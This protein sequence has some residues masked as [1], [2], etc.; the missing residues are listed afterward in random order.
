MQP[1]AGELL[2]RYVGDW[3][4]FSLTGA[5]ADCQVFLRTNIG[6]A[7][8]L[9]R[10]II[11]EICEPEVQVETA[12]RDVPMVFADG[13]WAVEFALAE[14]GWF[15]AKAYVVDTNGK[16]HWP[17]GEN[18]GLSVHP[19]DARCANTIYC[20]FPRMFGPNKF[21]RSTIERDDD[22][23]IRRLDEEGY[24]V[25]PPSGTF[26]DV[27]AELP[28][29][30]GTLG[31][32]I[33]H[34]LPVNSTPTTYAR[35]GR[36]G[37]PYACG[38]LTDIDSALVE[39]DKR[40]TGVQQFCELTDAV[41]A[42]GG[43][44]FL[45]LVI[46]HTGWGSTLQENH[47]EW[48]LRDENGDFA[49]PGAWGVTWGDL[50]EL[51]PHHR[52]LW[53]HLADAFLTWCRRGVDG[54]RCDAG[55]KVP[56]PV[57]R[58]IIARVRD[59]FPDTIFLLEGLG[60][61]WEDTEALLTRGGMQWAYSELF[62]EFSGDNLA[63]YLD[64]A[65]LQSL[66][67]G[68]LIHYSETHDNARLADRGRTW[69]LMRNQLSALTSVNG[70]Y[71]F[72]NGVE[73]L[74]DE[75][76]NVH[77]ARGMNWGAETNIIPELSRL[78]QLLADHPSFRDGAEFR[79]LSELGS[80]VFALERSSVCGSTV[81]ILVNSDANSKCEIELQREDLSV[82]DGCVDLLTG[83]ATDAE[84]NSGSVKFKLQ[85]GEVFCLSGNANEEK[86]DYRKE[87]ARVAWAF[88]CLSTVVEPEE[89]GSCDWRELST[90]IAN[91]PEKFLAAISSVEANTSDFIAGLASAI[92]QIGY[93]QVVT[94]SAS[95]ANRVTPVPHGHWLMLHDSQPFR[96][97]LGES[98]HIESIPV[99]SGHVAAFPPGFYC[100]RQ[101]TM[102]RLNA[103]PQPIHGQLVF[104]PDKPV[105]DCF[106]AAIVRTE[107]DPINQPIALL[108][109]RR[110]AMAR[111]GVGLGTIKSKYD[112][113]LG[114][115]LHD[116]LP[117]NRQVLVKRVRI[118]AVADG[119]I[120]PLDASNLLTFRPG[121]QACWRFLVSA[122]DSRT[123]EIELTA[124]MPE[125][126]N[127]T[128]LEM[129]RL[130]SQPALGTTLAAGIPFSLTVRVDVEDRDFHSET[131][132]EDG[133]CEWFEENVQELQ[134]HCGF[135]FEPTSDRR[136]TV[137]ASCGTFHREF[138]WLKDIQH[139]V[140]ASRGHSSTGG[141]CSPGWF[142]LALESGE[143]VILCAHAST[144]LDEHKPQAIVC[145]VG[146]TSSFAGRLKDSLEQFIVKRGAGKTVIAGYPW[147]LDWGRDT[148]IVARGM[149]AAGL[150]DDV[151][152]LVAT[153]AALE[154]QGTL[155]NTLHGDNHSNRNT[156]DAPLWLGVV[157][158]ELVEAGVDLGRLRAG[159]RSVYEVL[160]SIATHYRDGTP[161]GIRVDP[162]SGLVW[163][164]TH[165]TWMDT[166]HPAGSP[167]EGY[168]IE[169]QALWIRLLRLL[170][171]DWKSMAN[172]AAAS[173]A[174]LYK[175]PNDW[176]ADQL[177]AD[178]GTPASEAL[179]D[180]SLRSNG[181]LAVALGEV[182]GS[183][184]QRMVAAARRYLVVPGGVRSLAPLPVTPPLPVRSSEGELLNDPDRPYCGRYEGDED[185]QRKPAYH[186]GTAWVWSLPVFC[187]AL[188][189]AW[190]FTP[191]SV[192]AARSYL[193]SL[194]PMLN[195]GCLG[196]LPEVLDGD[197]PHTQRGCDAQAWSVSEAYRVWTIL[198]ENE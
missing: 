176:L 123:V 180:N 184:A 5:P 11:G 144:G 42:R 95:D 85:P 21:A 54:F 97:S 3:L 138:E 132:L 115:N 169:I 86:A 135:S 60:G 56:M 84:W 66:R 64:H 175:I 94:W 48:F 162:A 194:E 4:R 142:E 103:K 198:D 116:S 152:D 156:S 114:A 41:H 106:D 7:A 39:F 65:L 93:R 197:A 160:R 196:H 157:C 71:A 82:G 40:A 174:Q 70:G 195:E 74:A 43:R 170:G 99:D 113:L 126:E 96:A 69:S 121:S 193:L 188:V 59:E 109:N 75:K 110:G 33:L 88:R 23:H 36:F 90:L 28:H 81:V 161:N 17:D 191:E 182:T 26:R 27:I 83:D 30:M 117:V 141:A 189:R 14:V 122:A 32:R 139:P 51:E 38:D 145:D 1:A 102:R 91:E 92:D 111:M 129:R 187:E 68:T 18:L 89:I 37:S 183:C 119:F 61:S 9:R 155:P 100:K 168:P 165:F 133:A 166:N 147:F 118:W 50:V 125:N 164:P 136:L 181:L 151:R 34:L 13:K 167:R 79:R 124:S 186:N 72:T 44:L 107:M 163:S 73:W 2:V 104:L 153:F 10:E 46:N 49:S 137:E 47:P 45:D 80:T 108:T 128:V 127:T 179:A 8:E 148:L 178:S 6:R 192:A 12:W 105:E 31:C 146:Q 159:D 134:E 120:T 25:I 62:Q 173:L 77:N 158:G 190:D 143:K 58:Y 171:D 53:E 19:N 16:Q 57:W 63:G 52:G 140:E 177:I 76:V 15:Q 24:S 98:H 101:L 112:C 29:I 185:T 130:K 87:R 150:H 149:L 20:C 78:N 172:Q 131:H 154:Q 22:E 35:M 67:I 55:Y